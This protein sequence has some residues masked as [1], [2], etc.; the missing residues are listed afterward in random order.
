MFSGEVGHLAPYMNVARDWQVSAGA[1]MAA[2]DLEAT[3][4][5]ARAGS[6]QEMPTDGLED[7]DDEELARRAARW[8][9]LGCSLTRSA[10]GWSRARRSSAWL[11]GTLSL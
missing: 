2:K 5:Q 6:D 11:H 10:S 8:Q 4:E 3:P 1:P 7:D 9:I